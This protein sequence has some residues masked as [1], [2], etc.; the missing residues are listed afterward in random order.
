MLSLQQI[1]K[2]FA[3]KLYSL[4][5]S[6]PELRPSFPLMAHYL[7]QGEHLT[8]AEKEAQYTQL[9]LLFLNPDIE[10]ETEL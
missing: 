7:R 4:L 1:P 5:C 2:S 6:Q 10:G 3:D 8:D 9:Q